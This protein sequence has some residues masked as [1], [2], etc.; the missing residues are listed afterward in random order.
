MPIESV[1]FDFGA[2]LVEC[3]CVASRTPAP[4]G[5]ICIVTS[6]TVMARNESLATWASEIASPAMPETVCRYESRTEALGYPP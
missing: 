2:T 6:D 5:A 4:V 3:S 1:D